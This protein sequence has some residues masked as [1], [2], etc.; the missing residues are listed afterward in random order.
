MERCRELRLAID[1]LVK[2][3]DDKRGQ[4]AIEWSR[5]VRR[6]QTIEA[7]TKLRCD[8]M[9]AKLDKRAEEVASERRKLEFLQSP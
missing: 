5:A 1:Q 4:I 8:R 9:L 3:R 6:Q 7:E 2:E